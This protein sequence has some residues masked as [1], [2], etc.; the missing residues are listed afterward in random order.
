M[1]KRVEVSLLIL[2]RQIWKDAEEEKKK[3]KE[4]TLQ[5]NAEKKDGDKIKMK[6]N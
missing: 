5:K 3:K 1:K 6:M 2:K 4:R